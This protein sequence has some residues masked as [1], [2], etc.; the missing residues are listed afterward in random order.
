MV[1]LFT[2]LHVALVT[3]VLNVIAE[4]AVIVAEPF[5]VQPLASV[6]VTE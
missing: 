3:F 2:P 5:A 1:P 4:G 6:T